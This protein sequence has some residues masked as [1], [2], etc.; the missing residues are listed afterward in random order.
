M[1]CVGVQERQEAA[2]RVVEGAT[3]VTQAVVA[4][5]LRVKDLTVLPSVSTSTPH[6]CTLQPW[7]PPPL[8]CLPWGLQ[9]LVP[10]APRYKQGD[11][12]CSL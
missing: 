8:R 3:E 6:T 12:A 2:D 5:L 7:C 1:R 10:P 11:S 9:C 4:Q